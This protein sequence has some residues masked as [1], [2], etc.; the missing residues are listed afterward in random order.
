V[1]ELTF[2]QSVEPQPA[3]IP[4]EGGPAFGHSA[5]RLIDTREKL[6]VPMA[7]MTARLLELLEDVQR[8]LF[9]RA[10]AFRDDHTQHAD[11]YDAFK[12]TLEGRPGFVLARWC[13]TAACEAQ[14]KNDTQAT[15]RN[16][17]LDGTP[18]EGTCVRCD[19]PA[20][21]VV[22]FAKSY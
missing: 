15:I 22:R 5:D 4:D 17:P 10:V 16:I 19:A 21:H 3:R 14:I 13:G 7:G 9:A 1:I 20:Q 12:Q 2:L 8:T 18:A 11:T 6:G